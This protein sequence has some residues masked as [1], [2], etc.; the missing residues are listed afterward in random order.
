MTYLLGALA[1]ILLLPLAVVYLPGHQY[2]LEQI[3][4]IPDVVNV[5]FATLRKT[6]KP[7]QYLVCPKGHCSETP[8]LVARSYNVDA[9]KLAATWH[10]IMTTELDVEERIRNDATRQIE[11]VQR[12]ER[13]RYPDLI[14]V[15]FLEGTDGQSTIAIYSRSIYG[16]SD[17]GVN[18]VRVTD[19]L[20]KLDKA[21]TH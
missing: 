7:N 6:T 3:F 13:M 9:S 15:K 1:I 18:K 16:Y 10:H 20:T 11:Y 14:T 17:K 19:W 4:R 12:T 5:D 21:L 2:R 8:D